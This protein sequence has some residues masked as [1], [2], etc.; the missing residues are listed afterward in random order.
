MCMGRYRTQ[1]L[2]KSLGAKS[3]REILTTE[4]TSAHRYTSSSHAESFLS[5]QGAQPPQGA[6]ESS[7]RN[8]LEVSRETLYRRQHHLYKGFSPPRAKYRIT[9]ISIN[10]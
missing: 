1:H 6:K 7:P 5:E 3:P 10:L 2:A 9:D 8:E 4:Q